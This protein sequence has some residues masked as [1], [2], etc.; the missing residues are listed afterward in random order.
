MLAAVFVRLMAQRATRVAVALAWVGW[1][2][3]V[4]HLGEIRP[5]RRHG[6]GSPSFHPR[7]LSSRG[8]SMAVTDSR[9]RAIG[10]PRRL[11]LVTSEGGTHEDAHVDLVIDRFFAALRHT[12]GVVGVA[13]ADAG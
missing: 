1:H 5:E 12:Y 3:L 9:V 7:R 10:G 4:T 2:F 13:P 11:V 8:E 6:T